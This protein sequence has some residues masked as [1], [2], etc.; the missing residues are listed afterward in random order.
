MSKTIALVLLL[1]TLVVASVGLTQ[2][3][4]VQLG[5]TRGPQQP[6]N[7]SHKCCTG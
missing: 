5:G 7:F 6:I 3:F 4:N 2:S 1:S